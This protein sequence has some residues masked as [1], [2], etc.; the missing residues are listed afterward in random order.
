ML[1]DAPSIRPSC[2]IIADPRCRI[3]FQ[4]SCSKFFSSAI[5]KTMA[6]R[7]SLE[8]PGFEIEAESKLDRLEDEA[9]AH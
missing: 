6:S 1:S 9:E 5:S 4:I 8:K 2:S 7:H 3:I